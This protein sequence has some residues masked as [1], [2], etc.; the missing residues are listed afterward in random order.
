MRTLVQRSKPDR[1]DEYADLDRA[2]RRAGRDS[3]PSD[4][5]M[6]PDFLLHGVSFP[7]HVSTRK[8]LQRKDNWTIRDTVGC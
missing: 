3:G 5:E 1:L 8:Y 6:E 7:F 4:K 2:N